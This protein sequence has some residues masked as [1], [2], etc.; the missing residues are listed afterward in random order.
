MRNLIFLLYFFVSCTIA[1]QELPPIKKFS[2]QDYGGDN[3]NWM[4]SQSDDHYIYVAN[5]NGLL[6][7]DGEIWKSYPTPN[8]S[9][10]RAVKV[11]GRKIYTG[12]YAEFGYWE[13]DKY[14][15][16]YYTS[17]I[18]KFKNIDFQDDQIWNIIAYGDWILF[19][20]SH[21]LFF[22]NPKDNLFKIIH[23][24]EI[25]YKVFSIQNKIYYHVANMGLY[26]I[27]NGISTLVVDDK[28]IKEGRVIGLYGSEANLLLLTRN[29]GFFEYDGENLRRWKTDIDSDLS[30]MN[31]FTAI[32]LNNGEFVLG[33]ILNGLLHLDQNGKKKFEIGQRNGLSNNTVLSLFEDKR[34]NLWVGL[35]N[36]INCLNLKSK[37]SNY[38]DYYGALGTVYCTELYKGNFYAGTNQGLFYR[39]IDRPNQ[40]FQFIK[41]TAG[42]VWSLFNFNDRSL[43]CGHHLGTFLIEG[44]KSEQI[45][46]VLGAWDFRKIPS[47]N[48]LLLQGNYNGLHILEFRD[49]EWISKNKIKGFKYSSR[50]IEIDKKD[51]IWVS[52][53]YKGVFKIRLDSSYE[54]VANIQKLTSLKI[55]KTSSLV[56]YE[57]DLLYNSENGIYKY[58]TEQ[59]KFIKDEHLHQLFSSLG[60]VSGRLTVD[61]SGKLWLFSEEN[62]SYLHH[63]DLTNEIGLKNIPMP[64]GLR[65]GILGFENIELL[66]EENY[67]L[68]KTDGFLKIDLSK[69]PPK[70]EHRLF[71]NSVTITDLNGK[72]KKI[73]VDSIAEFENKRGVLSFNYSVPQYQKFKS[74][75]YSYKLDGLLNKWSPWRN[76][77]SVQFE[78]LPF[79]D[80]QLSI[81]AKV[82]NEVVKN[83][84]VFTFKVNKPW[85]ISNI[86]LFSYTI[87]LIFFGFFVHKAYKFYYQK[88]LRHEQI[89][90]E[91]TII[92]IQNE[93]LNQGMENK[94]R[95][96][97]ISTMSIIKKNELLGKI[98]KQLKKGYKNE[99]IDR[100]INLIENNLNNNKDWKFFKQAFDNADKEFLT[101]IKAAHPELTPN[102]LKFCAYLRLNLSSKEIAPLLNISI[103]SV[104][105]KRYR[106]RKRLKLDHDEHLVN[107]ILKF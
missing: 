46:S 44:D 25:I 84:E 100:A 74:V 73:Q 16:L 99:N 24:Q 22:Y 41:G 5:N 9:I 2:P 90:N 86:A 69:E 82:G 56:S 17:L 38:V 36:G 1:A 105:T 20:S 87:F 51:N 85:Y 71:L 14:G 83:K 106:L 89:Q 97:A 107:Y 10:L 76:S 6:E 91:K 47:K 13:K 42:Q 52:N 103:K 92:E 34:N 93:R 26:K 48:N 57:D 62:I 104:E 32:K 102:D 61:K 37:I 18:S 21:K 35:D 65:N 101:N 39:P 28:I 50:F 15:D 31:I 75:K 54:S 78:N 72:S 98:K 94:N 70:I 60:K 81:K 3:Q 66:S 67:I 27:E 40:E 4:V 29:R 80:Y 49:G 19:Q 53:E 79:G 30:Q 43:L 55:G 33:T 8:N 96:L 23:S 64:S 63:N 45:S 58:N 88:I 7:Y 95:E 68:G 77:P 12:C 59:E 11:I